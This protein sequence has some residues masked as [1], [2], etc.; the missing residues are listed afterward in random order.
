MKYLKLFENESD[1]TQWGNTDYVEPHVVLIS[2]T[3]KVFYK[4]LTPPPPAQVGD[5]AYWNG[6]SVKTTP[7]SSWNTSLGT[8]VGVVMIPENFLPDDKARIISLTNMVYNGSENIVWDETGGTT[9]DS[10]APN[11]DNIVGTDNM[12]STTYGTYGY[13]N[14]P[15]DRSDWSGTPSYSDSLTKYYKTAEEYNYIGEAMSPSPYLTNDTFNPVYGVIIED[16]N[17][18]SDFNGL[19]NTQSLVNEGV[20]YHAAHACWNY[21]DLANSNLQ[22][23]LPAMGELG[24]LMPRFQL[25]NQSIQAVGGTPI[26][27]ENDFWSS[28]EIFRSGFFLPESFAWDLI[29]GHGGV[30]GHNKNYTKCVRSVAVC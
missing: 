1:Y 10:S 22:W 9:V 23:Y 24:F 2:T 13:G 5:I 19:A 11:F 12:G 15:S 18:L 28:S 27:E 21:K 8:P 20:Q 30:Y 3:D 29:T 16:G 26:E 6:S 7:L 14:L 4:Q 25:I 17:V